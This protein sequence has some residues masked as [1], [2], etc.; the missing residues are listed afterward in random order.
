MSFGGA[1]AG[2]FLVPVGAGIAFNLVRGA[3]PDMD[4]KTASLIG[5]G[6]SAAAAYASYRAADKYKG[7]HDFYRGGMWGTGLGA[8][9]YAG[10]YAS[11]GRL[12]ASLN[13]K[14]LSRT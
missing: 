13:P 6:I 12:F 11:G 2:F 3:K 4:P 5:A 14:L 9:F 7:W 10:D 1:I 8:A